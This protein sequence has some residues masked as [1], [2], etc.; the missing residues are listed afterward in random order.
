MPLTRLSLTRRLISR[1]H[2]Q[3]EL[4]PPPRARFFRRRQEGGA[5]ISRQAASRCLA[6]GTPP[7]RLCRES[8]AARDHTRPRIAARARSGS[9]PLYIRLPTLSAR[10]ALASLCRRPSEDHLT[11]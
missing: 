8:S 10:Y 4:S 11:L 2:A 9:R 6:R 5:P 1:E 7:A 3:Y